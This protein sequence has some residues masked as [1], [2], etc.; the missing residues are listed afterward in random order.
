MSISDNIIKF[1]KKIS[2][3]VKLIAVSKT[4]SIIEIKE[5]YD[6][7]H[8][9]FGENKVQEMT[10]KWKVLPKD[11][12][13]HMIGH[14]QKNKVKYIAPYVSLIHSVDS[15]RLL[16]EINKQAKKNNRIINCLI[17]V[18]IS[19][20]QSK[21]G[22]QINNLPDFFNQIIEN[23]Y[24]S[25]EII[26]LMGMA[27]FTEN[28]EKIFNEFTSLKEVFINLKGKFPRF[29]ELSIGMSSDYKI[30]LKQGSTMIRIGSK[31]FGYRN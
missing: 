8:K 18:N 2:S 15:I 16:N 17:Q 29:S 20:E 7:N 27:S 11:I 3:K 13:W 5:A 31:I 14:L 6:S 21:F 24:D 22:L 26:G 4:K 23:S 1:K 30:A 9:L 12:E 10:E 25:I 28:E 19:E